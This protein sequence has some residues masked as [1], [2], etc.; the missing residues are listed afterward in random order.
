MKQKVVFQDIS[1]KMKNYWS[2]STNIMQGKLIRQQ[3][4]IIL[5]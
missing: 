5:A 3:S 1:R 2:L 4:L